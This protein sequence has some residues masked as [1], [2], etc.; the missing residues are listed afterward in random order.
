MDKGK[1]MWNDL[2]L[3]IDICTKCILERTRINPIVGEGNEKAQ[4]LFV[5]DSVSEEEDIK[6][7]LL[8]DKNGKYFRRFLE[9]SKLDL[10]KCYFTTLTKCSSHGNLIEQESILK[11]NEFLI[12]QIALINPEYI[13]TVGERATKSLLENE[14]NEDIKDLVGKVFDFYGEIKIVP[15]YDISYL[16]KA[17]DKEKWKLIKILEYLKQKNFIVYKL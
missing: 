5:L 2:K 16:F 17:T 4:V 12:A 9:Y 11:C 1:V 8:A 6:Q 13:V 10:K 3:E 7:Q 15:I 14:E